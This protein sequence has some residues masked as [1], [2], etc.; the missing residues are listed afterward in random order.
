MPGRQFDDALS[1]LYPEFRIA[2]LEAQVEV[3]RDQRDRLCR[4]VA[5]LELQVEISELTTEREAR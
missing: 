5:A 4:R 3:L 1:A 2:E